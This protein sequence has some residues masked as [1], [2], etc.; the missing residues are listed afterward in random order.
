MPSDFVRGTDASHFLVYCE[1]M[2]PLMGLNIK[3]IVFYKDV[4]P[5]GAWEGRL[6]R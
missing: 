5:S 4:A 1:R 2:S 3:G 6:E